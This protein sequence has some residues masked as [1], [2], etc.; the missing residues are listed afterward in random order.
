VLAIWG[1]VTATVV[2]VGVSGALSRLDRL[3]YDLDFRVRGRCEVDVPLLILAIDER[4][5]RRLGMRVHQWP[6]RRYLA[7]AVRALSDAG[8]DVIAIDYILAGSKGEEDRELIE[9]LERCDC[10]VVLAYAAGLK[11]SGSRMEEAFLDPA[12]RLLE[13][14]G[15]CGLVNVRVDFDGVLRSIAVNRKAIASDVRYSFALTTLL[16]R[17]GF[18]EGRGEPVR[19]ED[20]RLVFE[21]DDGR[22]RRVPARDMLINFA[23]PPGAIPR[24]SFWRALEGALGDEVRD[25][26]VVVGRV[27]R[28]GGDVYEVPT[29]YG[30]E[31]RL[32]WMSGAEIHANAVWTMLTERYLLPVGAPARWLLTL[33]ALAFS[34]FFYFG[35]DRGTPLV[36][37]ASC[38]AV[39]AIWLLQYLLFRGGLVMPVAAPLLAVVAHTPGGL[40]C[41]LLFLQRAA[42]RVRKLFGRYVSRNVVR[43]MIEGEVEFDLVGHQKEISVLFADIRDFTSLSAR[44]TP[45]ETGVLLNRFFSRL[46]SVVFRRDGT[47]D[48]LMGDCVMAFFNDP[49]EQPDHAARACRTALEMVRETAAF[50]AGGDPGAV[51]VRIGVGVGTGVATVGNLGAPEFYDYTAVGENVNLASRLQELTR[52]YDVEILV[53]EATREA[54]KDAFLFRRLDLVLVRGGA[55]PVWIHQLMP[56]ADRPARRL[57][58]GFESAVDLYLRR[59]FEAAAR[60][61]SSLLEEFPSDAPARM[62]AERCALY[63][64]RPPPA[65]WNGVFDGGDA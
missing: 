38:G 54:A 28:M 23:G 4:S 17:V 44:L 45:A 36:A 31:S 8:A 7:R 14:A 26:I 53:S 35:G 52:R 25:A 1:A 46:I 43:K 50:R 9:A 2:V 33:G 22:R 3:V 49:D 19:E 18:P 40:L 29:S 63:V 59:E 55:S 41:R 39:V 13:A 16:G 51:E 47:L 34:L 27:G 64:R 30:T 60:A 5:E 37:G 62:F 48:K 56:E 21:D 24:I 15:M 65:D 42:R 58:T 61:F 10:T 57:A 20:G 11:R 32:N 12:P 6:L